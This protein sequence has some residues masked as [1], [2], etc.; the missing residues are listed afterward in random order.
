VLP[1]WYPDWSKTRLGIPMAIIPVIVAAVWQ[2]SGFTMAMYLAGLRG[3]P[4]EIKE[5]ARVDGASEWQLFRRVTFPLLR[6]ITLSAVI[7]L[8]HISL[9]IF[10]LVVTMTGGGPGNATEVPGLLM[11]ALTFSQNNIAQAPPSR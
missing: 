9:K 11:Y 1:G 5:A 8:G 3:I 10:D 2:M 6:P 7:I 4:E